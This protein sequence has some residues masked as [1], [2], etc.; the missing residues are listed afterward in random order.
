[1]NNKI[2]SS[3]LWVMFGK[4]VNRLLGLISTII[5]VRLLTP[6]DFGLAAQAIV[7]IM[8]FQ[9]ISD[10]GAEQYVIKHQKLSE[11][12]LFSAWT[13][14][15]VLKVIAVF[16]IFLFAEEIAALMKED[17]LTQILRVACLVSLVRCFMSP[18]IYLLKKELNFK[19]IANIGIVAKVVSFVV[20]L[21]LALTLKNYWALIW[22]NLANII[23]MVIG[24]Y[25]VAPM[26]PKLTLEK[27]KE[28][29]NFTRSVFFITILGYLR[30][31]IDIF[32]I[33]SKFGNAST[34]LYSIAQ[35]FATLPYTEIVEPVLQPLFS[36]MAKNASNFELLQHQIFKYLSLAYL[37][38]VPSIL[39][40]VFLSEEIVLVVFGEQ[41]AALTPLF[42]SLSMLMMV[43]ATNG[44]FKYAFI[45]T[46]RMTG[47]I[48]LDVLG[49]VLV[50]S[51]LLL[52]SMDNVE[53]FA[54]YRMFIGGVV[55]FLSILLAVKILKFKLLPVFYAL[56]VPLICGIGMYLALF[57]FKAY[58][59]PINNTII[60]I[61]TSLF[62]G[63]ISYSILCFILI[64]TLKKL[65][66]IWLFNWD[67]IS[68]TTSKLHQFLL[69][70]WKR[71]S[72]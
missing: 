56:T 36:S 67:I 21:I 23:V 32:I 66:F 8:L 64:F 52:E 63:V 69:N 4:W 27:V 24:S 31:K 28:Q 54:Q 50:L 1:M 13:L 22:G 40:I 20:T 53:V 51:A 61:I 49:I 29:W 41:W 65:N 45:L 43:Y 7:I 26:M 18:G 35:E 12:D 59:S 6:E 71:P 11:K 68:L 39:G 3:Y 58:F 34:G 5:L 30:A 38:I 16:I 19:P 44:V 10:S 57:W 60:Y 33:G 17:R 55:Y 42:S 25:F 46:S 15:I 47:M 14:N 2:L 70:K 62:I 48:L 72:F 37:L 9:A